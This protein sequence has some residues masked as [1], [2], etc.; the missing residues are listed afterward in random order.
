M[1]LK[2][3]LAIAFLFGVLSSAVHAQEGG[4]AMDEAGAKVWLPTLIMA[5]PQEGFALALAVTLA[6]KGV[7]T[8]QT[9]TE[10]LTKLR[11]GYTQ[12]PD[13]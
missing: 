4:T 10:V 6:R 9:D 2:S 7:G 8:T 1:K 5:T 13:R 12:N 11:P 3:G